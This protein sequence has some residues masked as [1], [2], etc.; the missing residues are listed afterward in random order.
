MRKQKGAVF[1]VHAVNQS[2]GCDWV[3]QDL[4]LTTQELP[5]C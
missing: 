5:A 1:Q 2:G 3:P 4:S